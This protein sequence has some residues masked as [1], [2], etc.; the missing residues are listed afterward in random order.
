MLPGRGHSQPHWATCSSV[1]PLSVKNFFLIFSPNL[2]SSSLKPFPLAVLLHALIGSLSPAFLYTTSGTGRSPQDLLFSR[3]KSPSSLSLSACPCRGG[4][5]AL[6]SSL[7]PSSGPAP[8][9]PCP[10]VEGSRTGHCTPGEVSQEQ[11]GRITSLDLLITL[12]LMQLRIWLAFSAASARYWLM[13]N[14]SSISTPKSFSSGL[15]SGHS[16]SNL[17]LWL[18]L[19]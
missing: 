1:S 12:L 3:L 19:P 4:V 16:L 14:L 11:R 18:A 13:L 10:F 7:W 9:A 8:T 5:P 15:L 17:Y 2:T 6:R